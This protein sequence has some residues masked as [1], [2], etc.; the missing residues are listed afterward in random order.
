MTTF[1]DLIEHLFP[2]TRRCRKQ[3]RRNQ[4]VAS[5]R[6]AQQAE[7]LES[8]IYLSYTVSL[9]AGGVLTVAQATAGDESDL[10]FLRQSGTYKIQDSNGGLTFA[11][12][13]GANDGAITINNGAGGGPLFTVHTDDVNQIVFN[14]GDGDDVFQ[15]GALAAGI[16]DFTLNSGG[17]AGD[18][19]FLDRDVST[20]AAA[21][22]LLFNAPVVIQADVT[23]EANDVTFGE[24]VVATSHGANSLVVNS[25]GTTW[26]QDDVGV[27]AILKSLDTDAA[28]VTYFGELGEHDWLIVFTMDNAT[29]SDDVVLKQDTKILNNADALTF[30][31]TVDADVAGQQAL[32]ID[33]TAD[34]GRP[35]RSTIVT[36]NEAVGTSALE[37]LLVIASTTVIHADMTANDGDVESGTDV[38]FISK[39]TLAE[40]VT[41]TANEVQ[42]SGTVDGSTAGGQ[43]LTV[44]SPGYVVFQFDVGQD[45]ALKS[46]T[47]DAGGSTT[48]GVSADVRVTTVGGDLTFN[49]NL[50]ISDNTTINADNVTFG[51]EVVGGNLTVNSPGVTWFKDTITVGGVF[52]TDADGITYLGGSGTLNI[53]AD[54]SGTV[55]LADDVIL[56]QNVL[57]RRNDFTFA[58]IVR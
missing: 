10:T 36:F 9:D 16:D 20:A 13:G 27:G 33:T 41:L 22:D 25:D 58:K 8:R 35:F 6:L 26:F 38:R 24:T 31:G 5:V 12:G 53:L 17:E 23:I 54:S 42:F 57:V 37:Y 40:D 21:D 47:T 29:F 50:D 11:L 30:G 4:S 51:G 3:R 56:K 7:Q 19:L 18:R 2:P 15:F 28:G 44:N 14:L 49:D 1:R 32:Q 34:I 45:T 43:S 39:V 52:E 48:L 55:I 46:L